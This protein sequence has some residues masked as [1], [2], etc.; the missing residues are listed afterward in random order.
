MNDPLDPIDVVPISEQTVL[1]KNPMWSSLLVDDEVV[2]FDQARQHTH[3]LNATAGLVWRLIDGE[4]DLE[5]IASL[6]MDAYPEAESLAVDVV[7]VCQQMI[8]DQLA[9]VVV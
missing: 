1:L 3:Y 2:L 6:L 5:A 4:R 8:Q 9:L 7:S